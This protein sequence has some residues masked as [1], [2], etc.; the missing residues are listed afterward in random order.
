MMITKTDSRDL[1]PMDILLYGLLLIVAA[2]PTSV[3][4][5]AMVN[6]SPMPIY[7]SR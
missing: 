5:S 3:L 6:A 2:L 4:A 1:R 7:A